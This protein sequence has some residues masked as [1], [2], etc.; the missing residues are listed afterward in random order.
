MVDDELLLEVTMC[1]I[2]DVLMIL[3]RRGSSEAA[4]EH[5][6]FYLAGQRFIERRVIDGSTHVLTSLADRCEL[7][8]RVADWLGVDSIGS[9]APPVLKIEADAFA[10]LQRALITD[11]RFGIEMLR[12]SGLGPDHT[13]SLVLALTSPECGGVVGLTAVRHGTLT[14]WRTILVY[15]RSVGSWSVR[16]DPDDE[17]AL[18]IRLEGRGQLIDTISADIDA[19]LA[20]IPV[21]SRW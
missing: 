5:L 1:V 15:G 10:E 20:L 6:W 11:Q 2:P 16:A 14:G 19:C 7:L 18:S 9:S 17:R 4:R 21:E 12:T 13:R 3:S 8:A